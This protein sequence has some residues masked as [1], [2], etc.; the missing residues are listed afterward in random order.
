MNLIFATGISSLSNSLDRITPAPS[1]PASITL[2]MEVRNKRD[3]KTII[4]IDK[5]VFVAL[6]E[7]GEPTVHG[8]K[9][10]S[11]DGRWN[12]KMRKEKRKQPQEDS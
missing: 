12:K 10:F 7:F 2:K 4:T 11:S 6:N 9:S 3:K 5:I 8:M 1:L